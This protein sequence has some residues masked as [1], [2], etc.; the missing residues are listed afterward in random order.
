MAPPFRAG[1]E[2]TAAALNAAL[3]GTPALTGV[4]TLRNVADLQAA[5]VPAVVVQVQIACYATA[6]DFGG[7]L[8]SR[9]GLSSLPAHGGHVESAD[10][11]IWRLD[12]PVVRPEQFGAQASWETVDDGPALQAMFDFGRI[13][14]RGAFVWQR[15]GTSQAIRIN[16]HQDVVFLRAGAQYFPNGDT[17]GEIG[18]NDER[19]SGGW[20]I[21]RDDAADGW[22]SATTYG[23]VIIEYSNPGYVSGYKDNRRMA[24]LSGIGVHC[25]DSG[26][27]NAS[28]TY[29]GILISGAW[30]VTLEDPHVIGGVYMVSVDNLG[31]QV[32][33]FTMRGCWLF[34]S[35]RTTRG[36]YSEAG[37]SLVHDGHIAIA[38]EALIYSFGGISVRDM[39]LWNAGDETSR[40]DGV[41]IFIS[42][43][44]TYLD[45]DGCVIYDLGSNAIK[46]SGSP[47]GSNNDAKNVTITSTT[48]FAVGRNEDASSNDQRAAIWFL[49]EPQ[50]ALISGVLVAGTHP[51]YDGGAARC[52]YAVYVTG[53][54]GTLR[55]AGLAA[56]DMVVADIYAQS[57][58]DVTWGAPAITGGAG[59]SQTGLKRLAYATA[60][61]NY[62]NDSAAA[63]GGVAVGEVYRN[64]SVLMVRVS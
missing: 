12:D 49:G 62:A 10:G 26:G 21:L 33:D 39:R 2:L 64:G 13:E 50:N 58:V 38:S 20:I 17:I 25:N 27:A 45:V 11:T 28:A 1:T 29:A 57:G 4:A 47:S 59:W 54:G 23:V 56:A 61:G 7:G 3:W 34:G 18:P 32:N 15:Y 22:N 60:P 46:I 63:A 52:T 35:S 24:R 51:S 40:P 19:L 37:D 44:A 53:N 55:I 14:G 6:G 5:T 48:I 41:G 8:Y 36:L 16:A 30:N 9:T 43:A 31:T 42:S